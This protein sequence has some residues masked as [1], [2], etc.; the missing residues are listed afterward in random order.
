ME[1]FPANTDYGLVRVTGFK[2]Q[3]KDRG[4]GKEQRVKKEDVRH[5]FKM[6]FTN[7]LTT[8]LQTQ[9]YAFYIARNGRYEAFQVLDP[10]DA[11][12]KTMRFVDDELSEEFFARLQENS[13]IEM[14]EVAG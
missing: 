4:N 1:L 11:S 8:D 3:V 7:R 6:K 10:F 2:T 9:L 5:R 14:I 13:E 12:T